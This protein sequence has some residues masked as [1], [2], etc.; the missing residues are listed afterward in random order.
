ME[1]LNKAD[2]I[3][4]RDGVMDDKNFIL[5]TMLRG[6]YYGDTAF[7]DMEKSLFMSNYHTVIEK[8]LASSATTVRVACLKD[9]P[10]TILGYCIYRHAGGTT[11][12]DY[13]FTKSAWRHIGIAK[14]LVPMPVNFCTHLTKIGRAIKPNTCSYN[15][16]LL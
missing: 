15:P 11:V 6:I 9:D 12:L 4:V 1:Q 7:S 16:F 10:G 14:S 8:L 13:V 3:S 5:A 2:L